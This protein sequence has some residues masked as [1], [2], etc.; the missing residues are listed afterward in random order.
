MTVFLL[1]RGMIPSTG[2]GKFVKSERLYRLV[3]F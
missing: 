2:Q 1:V 3:G